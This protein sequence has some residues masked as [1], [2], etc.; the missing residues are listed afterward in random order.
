MVRFPVEGSLALM[1]VI[2]SIEAVLDIAVPALTCL[3]MIAVGLDLTTHDFLEVASSSK[4]VTGAMLGQVILLPAAAILLVQV[5]PLKPH[6]GTGLL[7]IAACPAGGLSNYFTYLARARTALSVSLT[8]GSCLAA[9][10]TMPLTMEAYELFFGQAIGFK[11]PA[12]KLMMDLLAMLVLPVLGGMALRH[13]QPVFVKRHEV[14]FRYVSLIGLVGLI[15][16]VLSQEGGHVAQEIGDTVLAGG[17]FLGLSM[18]VGYG[19]GF[20]S[21]GDVKD[22]FTLLIEFAGRNVAIAT[23]I[24]VTVLGR[25]EFAAFATAYFLI[26]VPILF[27]AVILFKR[28]RSWSF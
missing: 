1:D 24:T 20:A 2:P 5:L 25:I 10:V 3:L 28:D 22:R 26:E 18:A 11:V 7:L 19:T 21:G 9:V 27:S 16:Y 23:A 14:I 15:G 6:I 13:F 17:A 8:V 4:L 12:S